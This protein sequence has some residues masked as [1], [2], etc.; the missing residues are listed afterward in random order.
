MRSAMNEIKMNDRKCVFGAFNA[1]QLYL[2][3][4]NNKFAAPQS[5][6]KNLCDLTALA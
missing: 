6:H 2:Q 1:T 3:H 5:L 4:K